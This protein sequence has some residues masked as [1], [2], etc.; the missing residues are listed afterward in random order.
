MIVTPDALACLRGRRDGKYSRIVGDA[1][2]VLPD[3][4]GLVW[5]L[6]FLGF[7]IQERI[8]GVD[9]ADNLCRIASGHGF[10]LYFLGGKPGIAVRAAERMSKKYPGLKVNGARSGYFKREENDEI[11]REIRESGAQILLVGFGVPKQEYWLADN[12]GQLGGIVG[13]GVGGSFD[14]MSGRLKRAPATWRKFRLEWL[15][16]TFQEPY[17]W[18]RII[19][20]PIFVVLVLLKRIGLDFWRAR[21]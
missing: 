21:A 2:L 17:R 9:F 10:S 7:T 5:A 19:K 15:Y 6:R 4:S 1:G 13:M 8:P 11:C 12:L 14:V 3:G 16:R 18:R 20:L